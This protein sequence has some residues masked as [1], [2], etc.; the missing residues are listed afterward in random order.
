M[1]IY[2]TEYALQLEQKLMRGQSMVITTGSQTWQISQQFAAIDSIGI[3]YSYNYKLIPT[4]WPL[5]RIIRMYC[6]VKK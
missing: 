1:K 4:T 6:N 3:L 2:G 5:V